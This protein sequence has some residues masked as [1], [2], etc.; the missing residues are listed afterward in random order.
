MASPQLKHPVTARSLR[1][2]CECWEKRKGVGMCLCVCV[3]GGARV[4][5]RSL[6][7]CGRGMY[8]C[9]WEVCASGW[10]TGVF[11]CARVCGRGLCV[12]RVCARA[13]ARACVCVCVCVCVRC[14]CMCGME[15]E[16]GC[17]GG[18]RAVRNSDGKSDAEISRLCRT[19][20][21]PCLVSV[22]L[23]RLRTF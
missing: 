23:P 1:D 22:V 20:H 17:E 15:G 6:C 8:V 3:C 7:V 18:V 5:G 19:T 16:C 14:V 4:C 12:G 13:C 9:V 21:I 11:V 10:G 2:K